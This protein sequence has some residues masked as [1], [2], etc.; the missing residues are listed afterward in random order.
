[1]KV[2]PLPS[3]GTAIQKNGLLFQE[4]NIH[5]PAHKDMLSRE[6]WRQD[7]GD[8]KEESLPPTNPVKMMSIP[9]PMFAG[10]SGNYTFFTAG[11]FLARDADGGVECIPAQRVRDFAFLPVKG[12]AQRV[13]VDTAARDVLER[14]GRVR[15]AARIQSDGSAKSPI[16]IKED[17][18]GRTILVSTL[19]G[20]E[21]KK[22]KT[23]AW[24]SAAEDFLKDDKKRSSL[25]ESHAKATRR[26][27]S[28][29]DVAHSLNMSRKRDLE[30]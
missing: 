9:K 22:W 13:D 20:G 16:S 23:F 24:R 26:S 8:P 4:L 10:Q 7:L 25:E 29:L 27:Q 5:S 19:A 11:D 2:I 17:E 28:M 30:R 6:K 15:T 18:K 12:D 1:M 3:G 21:E 14:V